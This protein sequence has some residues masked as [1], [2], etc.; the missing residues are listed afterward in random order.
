M[1]VLTK[2]KVAEIT[3]YSSGG[4]GC[5]VLI[6]VTGPSEENKNFWK[7]TPAGK[8]ELHIDN[9]EALNQF[10]CMGEFYVEFKKELR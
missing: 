10:E 1:S 3:H 4:G 7:Y 2:F 6:P 5:V 8:I 9:P